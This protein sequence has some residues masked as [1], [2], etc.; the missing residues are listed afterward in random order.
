VFPFLPA[1]G[2]LPR[3]NDTLTL[4][5]T[6]RARIPFPQ[7]NTSRKIILA[8][9][10]VCDSEGDGKVQCIEPEA[11]ELSFLDSFVAID[12]HQRISIQKRPNPVVISLPLH[13]LA[14]VPANPIF[15]EGR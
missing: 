13:Q 5:L 10:R 4:G 9:V 7:E 6:V 2:I 11:S 12:Y 3:G 15:V 14:T 1:T 8:M